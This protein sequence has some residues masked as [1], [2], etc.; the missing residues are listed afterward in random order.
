MNGT[1]VLE[2]SGLV[3]MLGKLDKKNPK[4]EQSRCVSEVIPN[5]NLAA[6]APPY[7]TPL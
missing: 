2:V 3:T 7:L 6:A 1:E 4:L 5:T